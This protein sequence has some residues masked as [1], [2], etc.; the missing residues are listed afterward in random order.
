MQEN[1]K[2]TNKQG[3]GHDAETN[4]KIEY[5]VS[6]ELKIVFEN[7]LTEERLKQNSEQVFTENKVSF[8]YLSSK[9]SSSG[10]YLSMTYRVRLESQ[11]Q[12]NMLYEALKSLPGLKFA[13]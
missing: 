1:D 11:N 12:L 13:I 5:P 9:S 8:K 2:S 3:N 6:F 4:Q 10:N 7:M